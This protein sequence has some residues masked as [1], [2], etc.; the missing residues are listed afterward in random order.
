[1]QFSWDVLSHFLPLILKG[2]GAVHGWGLS[3]D[4]LN[5]C[6]ALLRTKV[7]CSTMLSAFGSA[8]WQRALSTFHRWDQLGGRWLVP[9]LGTASL[10]PQFF[11]ESLAGE[12]C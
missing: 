8:R 12:C 6:E 2:L 5:T 9:N 3:C 1:M 4:R 10:G 11:Q 7:S